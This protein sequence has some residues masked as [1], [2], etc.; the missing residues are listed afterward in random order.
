MMLAK[1]IA[2]G[3]LV[4][5]F[6]ASPI[7]LGMVVAIACSHLGMSNGHSFIVGLV[8]CLSIYLAILYV[9]LEYPP[10]TGQLGGGDPA[11]SLDSRADHP[12]RAHISRVMQVARRMIPG[13]MEGRS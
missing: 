11:S 6:M 1:E 8:M 9:K 4:M 2:L 5:I 10:E 12:D 7:W 3:S 13:Q